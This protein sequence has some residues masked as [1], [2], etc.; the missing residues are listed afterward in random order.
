MTTDPTPA[1]PPPANP[2]RVARA[3]FALM[4]VG[5]PSLGILALAAIWVRSH[6]VEETFALH[7][8]LVTLDPATDRVSVDFV[9]FRAETARGV[10]GC[11]VRRELGSKPVSTASPRS[12]TAPGQWFFKWVDTATLDKPTEPYR[13]FDRDRGDFGATRTLHASHFLFDHSFRWMKFLRTVELDQIVAPCWVWMIPLTLPPIWWLWVP[14]GRTLPRLTIRRTLISTAYAALILAA[15]T[16][17]GR[18]SGTDRALLAV[19]EFAGNWTYG[20]DPAGSARP[21][22][23]AVVLDNIYH[24]QPITDADIPRIRAALSRL[25]HL[26]SLKIYS[27]AATGAGIAALLAGLP[28]LE[29]L[30][31]PGTRA[32]DATM[33]AVAG[34]RKLRELHADNTPITD[35]GVAHLANHPTLEVLWLENVKLSDAGLAHLAGSPR[36]KKLFLI[37]ARIGSE[38]NFVTPI[39]DAALVRLAGSLPALEF[40]KTPDG[41]SVYEGSVHPATYLLER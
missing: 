3:S 20:P 26:R 32:N 40:I 2:R 28:N 7:R 16:A 18:S 34:C 33:A 15:L 10:L 17:V 11:Q 21:V 22:V 23:T 35:A 38:P 37:D 5:L 39:T 29:T 9:Q 1:T 24:R 27:E 25:P 31:F 19:E 12:S 4:L 30:E 14:P 6:Q 8:E 36:L 41:H 13:P